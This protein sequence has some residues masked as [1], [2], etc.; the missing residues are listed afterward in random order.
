MTGSPSDDGFAIGGRVRHRRSGSPSEVG[1]AVGSWVRHWRSGS[2]LEDGFGIGGRDRNGRS[3]SAL[4]V[5][6][7]LLVSFF[8]QGEFLFTGAIFTA[9]LFLK[10]QSIFDLQEDNAR[11]VT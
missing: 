6:F 5:S 7:C 2:E 1:F 9:N 8:L 3:G 4:D 11:H 10:H